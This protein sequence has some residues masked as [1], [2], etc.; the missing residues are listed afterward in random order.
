M[1]IWFTPTVAKY[2]GIAVTTLMLLL[3]VY[4]KGRHDV[5]VKFDDYKR[6]V[7]SLAK[8]QEAHNESVQKQ[9]T[10]LNKGVIDGYKAK[11]AAANSYVNG[12][13]YTGTS[14]VSTTS[15]STTGADGYAEDGIPAAAILASDCA[16][17]TVQLIQLQQW[18]EDQAD[19]K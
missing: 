19:I 13:H 12:L 17:T 9:Q 15:G 6:E 3:G 8:A 7:S 11:L 18:A 14:S 5:Q 2:A 4:I 16:A 10:L 1:P